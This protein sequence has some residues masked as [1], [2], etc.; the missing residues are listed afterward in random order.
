MPKITLDNNHKTIISLCS[1][2]GSWEKP[3]MEAGY[4]IIPITLPDNDVR[5]WQ[6]PDEPIHGILAAPPCTMFS[7]AR[8]NAKT[9]RDLA[10]GM[11]IV[12]A[13][14]NIIYKCQYRIKSDQQKYPPGSDK[15]IKKC[16]Y[17]QERPHY[18][19]KCMEVV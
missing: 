1:G 10:G 12:L 17:C 6:L 7:D 15:Q 2:L 9:P 5:T 19:M 4:K 14:L 11:E 18:C 16:S 13:C 3:Y 8:T